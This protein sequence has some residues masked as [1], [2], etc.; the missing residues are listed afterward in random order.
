MTNTTLV[1]GGTG[2]TGRRVARRL[3]DR[4]LP[5]RIGSRSGEPPFD[6]ADPGTWEAALAGVRSAY[7]AYYPDMSAPG[8]AET[9]G[10]FADLAVHKG[11]HR[12]VLLSGRGEEEGLPTEQ[13][14]RDSGA[15]WTI[16]RASWFSQ[17]FSEAFLLEP[18]RSGQVVLPA[19]NIA[20]PFVDVEDIADVAVAALT[21]D[22]HTGTIYEL[23]GPRLM[24]FGDAVGEIAKATDRDLTYFPVSTKEFASTLAE[25]EVPADHVTFLTALF[26]KVLDGRNAHLTNGVQAAIGRPPR[27]FTDYVRETVATGIWNA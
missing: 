17:N 9:V 4:G 8:A 7:L 3:T 27:D 1:T 12:L 26:T 5:V 23:T 21:E 22:R 10:A 11:V 25:H 13:A 15:K 6:W 14:V 18:I 16:L 2:K 19:G 24:T 20:E